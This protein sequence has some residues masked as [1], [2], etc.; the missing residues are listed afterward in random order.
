MIV[1]DTSALM[2]IVLREPQGGRCT[3]RLSNEQVV[4]SAATLTEALVVARGRGLEADVLELLQTLDL[5]V[6]PLTDRRARAAATAYA[7]FG[8]GVHPAKLNI[9]DVFA[10]ALA[11]EHACPL[12][13]V[14]DD[15]ART[16]V[17]SA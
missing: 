11:V 12:L 17:A 14:G 1:V 8:K 5:T 4:I 13:Y 6:V 9:C 16:D 10:Y 15:F 2:A 7:R 3:A